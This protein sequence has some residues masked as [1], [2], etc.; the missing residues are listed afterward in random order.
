ML[1]QPLYVSELC[2]FLCISMFIV[3]YFMDWGNT[4]AAHS[5]EDIY[6]ICNIVVGAVA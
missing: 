1:L 3:H 2:S 5:H 6:R 4:K